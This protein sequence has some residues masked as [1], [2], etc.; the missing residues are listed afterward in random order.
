MIFIEIFF[1]TLPFKWQKAENMMQN[2]NLRM[3]N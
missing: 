1:L 3:K 2:K